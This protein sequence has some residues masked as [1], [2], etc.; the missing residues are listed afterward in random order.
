VKP[1]SASYPEVLPATVTDRGAERFAKMLHGLGTRSTAAEA[2]V[3]RRDQGGQKL[4]SQ[5]LTLQAGVYRY[6]RR[7]T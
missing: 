5:L 6:S 4:E 1:R 3:R 7:S 2:M